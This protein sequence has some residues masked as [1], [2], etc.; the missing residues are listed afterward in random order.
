MRPC[1]ALLL[2]PLLAAAPAAAQEAGSPEP[3]V[4]RRV[5]ED[6][7]VRIEELRVRGQTQRIVVQ[8][9]KGALTR[10]YEVLPLQ[11]GRDPSQT[12]NGQPGAAGKRV[13]QVLSF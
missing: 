13:W 9:K 8:P 12:R 3:R 10:P 1:A 7:A 11:G 2:L 4:E 5:I 6:D